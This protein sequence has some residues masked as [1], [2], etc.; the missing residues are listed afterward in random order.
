MLQLR[1]F[2]FAGGRGVPMTGIRAA[3]N[4]AGIVLRPD[5][6][7]AP[8]KS[9]NQGQ[10][11]D[12]VSGLQWLN[13]AAFAEPDRFTLRNASRTLP[14]NRGP[15]RL[16]FDLMLAKNFYWGERWRAQ[17]RWE[18]YGFTNTPAFL[19]PNGS[20]GSG[21]FGLVTGVLANS[22]RIMQLG[23]RITF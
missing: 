6:P 13:D 11:A 9:P 17:F 14:G 8:F 15:W 3:G 21:S 12:G 10:Q 16:H 5:L 4:A 22:W 20:L 19:L 1:R 7:G 23:L 18:A 2:N